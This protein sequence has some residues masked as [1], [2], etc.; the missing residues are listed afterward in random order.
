[1]VDKY[2]DIVKMSPLKRYLSTHFLFFNSLQIRFIL[3]KAMKKVLL[4]IINV[5][6]DVSLKKIC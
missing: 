3:Q 1:M 6:S 4:D 2:V 5:L